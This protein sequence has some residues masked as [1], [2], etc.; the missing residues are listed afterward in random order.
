MLHP[1][2]HGLAGAQVPDS[3][4]LVGQNNHPP[5]GIRTELGCQHSALVLQW[6][7]RLATHLSV[8]DLNG[9]LR[10]LDYEQPRTISAEANSRD[11]GV[12]LEEPKQ[13]PS[14]RIP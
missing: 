11:I 10:F 9:L 6:G 14:P 13:L 7:Q 5:S 4:R 1:C 2:A 3:R 12:G 8:Q